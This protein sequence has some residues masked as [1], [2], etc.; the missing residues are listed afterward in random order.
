MPASR[1]SLV[2]RLPFGLALVVMVGMGST[3]RAVDWLVPSQFPTIQ[4]AIAGAAPGDRILVSPGTYSETI[5]FLGKA[6]LVESTDGPAVTIVDA[7]AFPGASVAQFASGEG[8]DSILAG[9]TLRGGEGSTGMFV[10]L[11]GGG[12]LCEGSSPTV[13]DN[14]I[15]NN[16]PLDPSALSLGA[17]LFA[18]TAST[19]VVLDNLF[20]DNAATYGG[21]I[22][23]DLESQPRIEGNRFEGNS[24]VRGGGIYCAFDAE[25]LIRR[26]VFTLN[27]ASF[28]G[29]SVGG[30]GGIYL[31]ASSPLISN[32]TFVANSAFDL[33][34]A[35]FGS[36]SSATIV[37]CIF[38]GN[39]ALQDMQIDFWNGGMPTVTYSLVEGG[40][41][42]V[43]NFD[44]DPLFVDE[45]AGDFRLTP[46]SPCVDRGDPASRPDPDGTQ[47][48]VGALFLP[49]AAL[50]VRGDCN[51]DVAIDIADVIYL[52]NVL[53]GGS[54]PEPCADACDA[55]DDGNLN[56]ADTVYLLSFFFLPG[57]TAP[58]DPY[59][60]CG[61]DATVD[62]LNCTFPQCP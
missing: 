13:R 4:A 40:W 27:T 15:T 62:G 20:L 30:G 49:Q 44:Q 1:S 24:A 26:N 34:G 11:R 29:G 8:P 37:N 56:V 55:N 19:P 35:L 7:A 41:T 14:V 18:D 57:G 33:G 43:G 22:Y 17:G 9:F 36:A 50:L 10:G 21:G 47:S 2:S 61:V 39:A 52:L 60:T 42:G 31:E 46:A 58:P 28:V 23:C 5:D 32:N 54:G 45:A 53:F 48:D 16:G 38:R 25:P 59:P 6:I 51:R 12:V 3:A